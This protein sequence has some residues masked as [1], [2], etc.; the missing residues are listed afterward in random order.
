MEN[1]NQ[2][3][4]HTSNTLKIL[5]MAYI[6]AFTTIRI[7]C[8]LLIALSGLNA[9][10]V[11][12]DLRTFKFSFSSM[13]RL[14]KLTNTMRK[15]SRVQNSLKYLWKPNAIHLRTISMTK[16][17]EKTRFVQYRMDFSLGFS[18]KWIS[19]KQRVTDDA[20]MSTKMNHSNAGVSTTDITAV[21]PLVHLLPI[22]V[23][24]SW[25]QQ[26]HLNNR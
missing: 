21:L 13:S 25:F 26:M 8:H 14:N 7:P 2:K 23:C 18:S 1:I 17:I 12:K 20:K 22:G 6:N 10:R 15:S 19:S 16:I 3:T 5:G 9:L 4:K 24:S 11:L